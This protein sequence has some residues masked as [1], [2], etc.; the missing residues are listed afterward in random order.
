MANDYA[1][2]EDVKNALPDVTFDT[3]HEL[4]LQRLVTASSRQIDAYLKRQPGAFYVTADETRY[5]T[6]SGCTEQWIDELAA[7]PTSVSVAETGSTT[8]TLWAATDYILW[9]YN[10]LLEGVPYLR[11]DLDTFNGTQSLWYSYAKSIKVV[12]KFGFSVVTPPEILEATVI[13]AMRLFKRGQ[14]A[15]ADVGAIMDLGQLRYVKAIDP[16]VAMILSNPKFQRLT[17]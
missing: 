3:D 12:G 13:Q 15:F 8:Y 10:A 11:M 4:I 2:V 1:F 7:A 14:Q 16:D 9:P 17:L 5:Y 6:G